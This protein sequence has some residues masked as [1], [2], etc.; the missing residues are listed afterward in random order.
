MVLPSFQGGGWQQ[1]LGAHPGSV[2]HRGRFK[3]LCPQVQT[4]AEKGEHQVLGEEKF[5]GLA[6]LFLGQ[7]GLGRDA[8]LGASQRQGA[9]RLLSEVLSGYPPHTDPAK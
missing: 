3:F 5:P 9:R 8:A 1:D 2:I 6:Q 4:G 7:P